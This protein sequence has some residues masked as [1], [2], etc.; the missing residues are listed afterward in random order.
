MIIKHKEIEKHVEIQKTT[1]DKI[2][3]TDGED[4]KHFEESI[5]SYDLD[6]L[7]LDW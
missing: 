4:R 5:L 3:D 7:G 2:Y 1:E 6:E